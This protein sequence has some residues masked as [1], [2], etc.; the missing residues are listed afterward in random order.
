MWNRT[1]SI[2]QTST[3]H[4]DPKG[5]FSHAHRCVKCCLLSPIHALYALLTLPLFF[6]RNWMKSVS[7]QI[8]NYG[9]ANENSSDSK[10]EP[11]WQQMRTLPTKISYREESGYSFLLHRHLGI[12]GFRNRFWHEVELKKKSTRFER[13]P[14]IIKNIQ[15][16]MREHNVCKSEEAS[17]FSK[18]YSGNCQSRQSLQLI[19]KESL[20]LPVQN[21]YL[22]TYRT[23]KKLLPNP[24]NISTQC[25]MAPH[26]S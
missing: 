2:R 8:K 17:F 25:K 23:V 1:F 16:P 22:L 24:E 21:I 18:A 4:R 10:W 9:Y 11:F 12:G 7:F 15:M 5:K 26:S 13:T 19:W 14:A 6:L 20:V 3:V